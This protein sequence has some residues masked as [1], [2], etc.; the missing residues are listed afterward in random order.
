MPS[1]G[2]RFHGFG[3]T[4]PRLYRFTFPFPVIFTDT[5]RRLGSLLVITRV[6]AALPLTVGAK[7]TFTLRD[8]FGA[9]APEP[10]P[11]VTVNGAAPAG[12]VT[13][14]VPV[15]LVLL[16]VIVLTSFFP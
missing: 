11:E 10:P 5:E 4:P 16:S 15:A 14:S 3:G 7:V 9:M 13:W 1:G 8:F 2:C 6:P 12:T